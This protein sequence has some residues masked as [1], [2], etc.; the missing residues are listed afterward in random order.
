MSETTVLLSCDVLDVKNKPFKISH[1]QKILDME[2]KMNVENW[3]LTDKNFM[4]NNGTIERSNSG[5][6][7]G[8]KGQ[9]AAT[10]GG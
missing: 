3:K 8:T 9:T 7:K 5:A 6:G 1:A 2:K 10:K 4:L